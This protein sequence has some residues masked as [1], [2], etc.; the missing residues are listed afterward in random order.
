MAAW[1]ESKG[2]ALHTSTFLGNPLACAAAL[3]AI[4]VIVGDDLA[5]RARETG[6]V[7]MSTLR[8]LCDSYPSRLREVRGRGLM[9]GL[10]TRSQPV[11]DTLMR[12][13][14]ANGMIVLPA[15]DGSVL[16]FVPPLNI[17]QDEVDTGMNILNKILAAMEE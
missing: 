17:S 7:L 4:D 3:V 1:G 5:A 14:L 10:S 9:V 15:G 16:E 11:A 13:C 6:A 8:G 2:E 12:S